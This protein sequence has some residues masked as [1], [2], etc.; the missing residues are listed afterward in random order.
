[1]KKLVDFDGKNLLYVKRS[2]H[3]S[4][5][6]NQA[7]LDWVENVAA[8][9]QSGYIL[10]VDY[11]KPQSKSQATIQVRAQHRYLDSPLDGFGYAYITALVDWTSISRCAETRG[12]RLS[13]FTDQH[14]FLT[15]IISEWQVLA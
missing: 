14:H 1:M 8:K 4:E 13:G 15:G 11:G 12:L 7:A 5:K 3:D 6:F 10:A 2:V 9:L